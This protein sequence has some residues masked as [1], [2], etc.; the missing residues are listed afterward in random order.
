[1]QISTGESVFEVIEKRIRQKGLL[2]IPTSDG[3]LEITTP[4]T[5][6]AE[7]ALAQGV[8]LLSCAANYNTKERFSSYKVKGSNNYEENGVG[9]FSTI[10]SA[11]DESVSRYR[12]LLLNGETII[13]TASAKKR[14]EYEAIVRAA[15]SVKVTASVQ[16]FRQKDKGLIW[17][18]NQLVRIDAPLVGIVSQELLITDVTFTLDD[19]SGSV[20][21]L[22]LMRKDAFIA[23]PIVPKA[24][25]I[26]LGE[27]DE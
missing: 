23:V 20:T 15:R 21:T 13:D 9:G 5:D 18:V 24:K 7:T 14:A 26:S 11:S 17:K 4:G 12:P 25:D 27:A 19:N 3:A 6:Y 1:V 2:L 8:N 10:G 22:G 16:G